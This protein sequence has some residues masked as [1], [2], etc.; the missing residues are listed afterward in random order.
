MTD[1]E[2]KRYIEEEYLRQRDSEIMKGEYTIQENA[3]N[4][5]SVVI[6]IILFLMF[7]FKDPLVFSLYYILKQIAILIVVISIRKFMAAYFLGKNILKNNTLAHNE[8]ISNNPSDLELKMEESRKKMG[9]TLKRTGLYGLLS[10]CVGIVFV[11]I[12]YI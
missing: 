9:K 6:F 2:I 11:F 1:E 4:K 12:Q 8:L 7:N 3:F 5:L 10:I